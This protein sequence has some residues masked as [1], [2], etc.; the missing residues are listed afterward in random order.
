MTKKVIVDFKTK[1]DEK[2]ICS[3]EQK[4]DS[5]INYIDFLKFI[6]L[7]GIF[8]A[9]V[10][11]PSW[12]MMLRSFDVPL[13][14]ILSAILADRSFRK[15]E[16]Q[17]SGAIKRF[18]FSRFKRLVIPTWF[19]LTLYFAL[20]YLIIGKFHDVKYYVYSYCL[21]RYG[22]KYVWIILIY[23]YSALLVPLY[24]KMSLSIKSIILVFCIYTIY[25]IAFAIYGKGNGILGKIIYT[26]LYSIIPYGMVTFLGFNYYRMSKKLKITIMLSALLF[27]VGM[28]V[29]YWYNLGS[30]QL[31]QIAK[32]PARIYYLSYGIFCSFALLLLCENHDMKIYQN[33]FIR[34]VSAHSMWVYLWHILALSAYSILKLPAIWYIKLIVVYGLAILAVYVLNKILDYIEKKHEIGFL[35][36]LRG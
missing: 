13:M 19:F 21:T 23:L 35:K 26:S 4:S 12:A 31:V 25:E 3:L 5:R 30:P 18:Y 10:D 24:R 36:Y 7:L 11:S 33:L 6:G 28:G 1:S 17:G 32:Y 15:Y 8:I 27:F 14:V 20:D 16:S 34:W 2:K 9:H 29:Y 22:I